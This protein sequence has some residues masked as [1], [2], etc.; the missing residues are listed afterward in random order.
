M[1]DYNFL[2]ESRLSPEQMQVL[3]ALSRI[4]A[5]QG[6]NL[7]LVGG[8][9]RDLFSGQPTIRDLDF[10]VEGNPQKIL[11]PLELASRPKGKGHASASDQALPRVDR[12]IPNRRL[13][14]ADL[15][16]AS[17]VRA[18]L[19]ASRSEIYARP[20]RPPEVQPAMIFEDLRRRDFSAN[21]MAISLH[22][23]S[24][25]LLLDPTNGA[26][27][28]A[29]RELRVLHSRSF[30]EDP[31]RIY[32]LLR[33]GQ[34]L[35][36]KPE[37]RTAGYLEAAI[38]N[39]RWEEM[40][41]EQQGLE[42]RAILQEENPGRV[43]KMLVE[44][45]LLRGLDRKLASTRI[46]YDRFAKIRSTVRAV[47]GADPFLLNFHSLTERVRGQRL[48]ARKIL[49]D[50]KTIRVALDLERAA[51]KLAR[52]LS[53]SKAARPSQVY[54]LLSGVP[55]HLLLFLLVH[56]P[57][58]KIQGRVKSYLF[59]FPQVRAKLPRSELQALGMPP[60]PKFE[61]IMDRVFVEQLDGDIKGHA[62]LLKRLRELA[63]IKEPETKT[64]APAPRRSPR[65][66]KKAMSG[67][68]AGKELK[69]QPTRG[70]RRRE[71]LSR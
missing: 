15:Y 53:S 46:P 41:P 60:G 55:Q 4:A 14:S 25:G 65:G 32:R 17:G 27:D 43:L 69:T 1:S 50:P 30:Q 52:V 64:P 33:L 54:F 24:R 39:H 38:E 45:G 35:D 47:P 58:V 5:G 40:L 20:G 3:N 10:V 29:Q 22:P 48:L 2:M 11:Q 36:F 7:Y 51:R 8:A 62:Q 57:Q 12:L 42:L 66:K 9:V 59:K 21:A 23:N 70:K 44:R 67:P 19:A 56:Y 34:R 49:P 68:P 37:A 18:E 61:K 63:G 6:S 28:I 26:A 16:F 31:S 71:P 13:D